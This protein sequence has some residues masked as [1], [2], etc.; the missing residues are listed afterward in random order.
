[1]STAEILIIDD[2]L[3]DFKPGL[4]QALRG[5][6]LRFAYSGGQGLKELEANTNIALV[7]LDIKMP[8]EL[9][10]DD[11]REGVEVL[12]RIKAD[13]PDVPVIM[14]TVL[15]EIDLV[16]EAVQAGAFHYITK[17]IDRDKLRDAVARALENTQLKAEVATMRRA[18]DAMLQVNTGPAAACGTFHGLIGK[19]PL[20][21]EL[22]ARIERAASF[23]DMSIV[24]LGESGA[25]KDL[26][27]RAIHACSP[28]AQGPFVAVN[29][30]AIAES[31]LDAELFGHEKGAYTGAEEAGEGLFQRAHGGTLFL[32]EIGDM[33]HA[34][35]VK[36]LRA[37][38]S[39][40]ITPVG[41]KPVPIDVRFVCATH[42]NLTQLRDA[43][44]F[45]EDL[46][47]RIWDIPLTL[48]PL[49]E[50][51]EDIPE[52]AAHFLEECKKRNGI[53]CTISPE[54]IAALTEYDWPG[55]VRELSATLRRMVVFAENG[56]ITE[57]QVRR[58]LHIEDKGGTREPAGNYVG[59][60]G[61][62]RT[63]EDVPS[64]PEY[65]AQGPPSKGVAR[66]EPG[67]VGSPLGPVSA[68]ATDPDRQGSNPLPDEY[69]EIT[70]LAEYCRLYGEIALTEIL[71][72]AVE[73][74]GG[75]RE[76]MALL[77]TPEEKYDAFRKWLQ[78]LGVKVRK[79]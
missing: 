75:V 8:A 74:G 12:K 58:A 17:P 41:G 78:R 46:F 25:G 22:Y 35:Q 54:A 6:T 57:A 64:V 42:R 49:R 9:A 71:T 7:L 69:P 55:N 29:C 53:Q 23:D 13:Y 36:L 65:A 73:E 11:M 47:Y 37:I 45:R 43:G 19:H 20:M 24:I 66:N 44:T 59:E 31:V 38:E 14:L 4:Q 48:P 32:D 68:R 77:G 2:D 70:D 5:H 26:A 34:L 27:A 39:G 51:R 52:L 1:M 18:R 21:H 50:R 30:G 63:P 79:G 62:D 10:A 56:R 72:R 60:G 40:E 61:N 76:A 3:G 67:D 16:V 15:N 33:P 28:R